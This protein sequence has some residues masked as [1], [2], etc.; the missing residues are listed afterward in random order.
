[1][2]RRTQTIVMTVLPLGFT[3]TA[4]GQEAVKVIAQE[5]VEIEVAAACGVGLGNRSRRLDEAAW[6]GSLYA[7]WRLP[8]TPLSLGGRLT[9]TN[10]GSERNGD[11]AGF[12]GVVPVDVKY[13]HNLLTTHLVL[14]YQPQPSLF[15]PFLE[16]SIGLGY[17]FTQVYRGNDSGVPIMV[18]DAILFIAGNGSE[19]LASSLAPSLGLGGGV[20]VRLGRAGAGEPGKRPPLSVS[21]NLQGRYLYVGTA[22][23]LE[24]EGLALDGARL[25]A[26]P[27]RSHTNMFFLGMGVSV[28]W[29][30]LSK[31]PASAER[32]QQP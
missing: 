2:R 30:A 6:G 19:T 26:E 24:S 5:T 32:D 21:L 7:G 31:R 16:T 17:F 20:K 22:T 15:T 29:G 12:S 11:L 27:R 18:G 4:A 1:M 13:S 3:A 25:V 9:M 14:R 10:Y 8:R 28:G 23:Y